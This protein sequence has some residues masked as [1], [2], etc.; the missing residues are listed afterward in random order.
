M[1]CC[2]GVR[3][4]DPWPAPAVA[5]SPQAKSRDHDVPPLSP[6]LAVVRPHLPAHTD[7]ATAMRYMLSVSLAGS[8]ARGGVACMM[9]GWAMVKCMQ[10]D[11]AV[12]DDDDGCLN[13]RV[14]RCRCAKVR[15][16]ALCLRPRCCHRLCTSST[17]YN[18]IAPAPSRIAGYERLSTTI[19]NRTARQTPRQRRAAASTSPPCRSLAGRP[20]PPDPK[21]PCPG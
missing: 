19:T 2:L 17:V 8:G 4:I 5:A 16:T 7:C 13:F 10:V 12:E 1:G 3:K 18:L 9:S 14:G 21:P 15:H 20:S 11:Q 6:Q